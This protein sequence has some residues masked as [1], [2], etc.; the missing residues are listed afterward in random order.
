MKARAAQRDGQPPR[1]GVRRQR[2]AALVVGLVLMLV[3]T[4]LGVSGMNTA[5]LELAMAANSQARQ[6]AFQA[7]ESGIEIA[8]TRAIDAGAAYAHAHHAF[9]DGSYQVDTE[10]RCVEITPVPETTHGETPEAL[11]MH[12]EVTAIGRGPRNAVARLT[13]GYYL[14]VPASALTT[15]E[16]EASATGACPTEAAC[17][18][19]ACLADHAPLRLVRT[20]W[21]QDD[22]DD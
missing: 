11:A 3:L 6:L 17:P 19:P 4:I 20:Y 12:F 1:P 13:Q 15:D 14:V 8:L 9:G 21:R 5:T 10:L 18:E 22:I 2:G 16:L 7:A